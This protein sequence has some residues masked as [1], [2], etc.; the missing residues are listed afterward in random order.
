MKELLFKTLSRMKMNFSSNE[1]STAAK[2]LGLNKRAIANGVIA[3]FLHLNAVQGDTRRMWTKIKQINEVKQLSQINDIN[4]LKVDK[5]D[6]ITNAI[7]L[8][9]SHGYKVLKQVS[10]WVYV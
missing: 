4:T 1:F 7:S 10:D 5:S 6:E 9:K 3:D 8:L 2:R